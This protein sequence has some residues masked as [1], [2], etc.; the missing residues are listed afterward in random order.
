MENTDTN[1]STQGENQDSVSS[2]QTGKKTPDT[3]SAAKSGEKPRIKNLSF[4]YRKHH[5]NGNARVTVFGDSKLASDEEADAVVSIFGSSTADG[6]VNDAVVSVLGS[7][8]SSGD[9]GDAV[10]SVLGNTRVNGG[11][12]GDAAVAVLGDTYINGHVRDAAVAVLGDI[13]LGPNA[14]VGGDVVSVGGTVK[15]HPNAIVHGNIQNVSIGAHFGGF[16]WFHVWVQ[17]CLL[18]GRPLAFGAQLMWAWWIAISFL[19]L[20]VVL[21]LLFPRGIE[22]CVQTLEHRPGYSLLTALL[23]TLITPL[24]AILLLITIVGL[25]AL[26]VFL[27]V[28]AIFGKAVMLT[29]IG[30]RITPLFGGAAASKPVIAVLVGGVIVLLLYTVP[31]V[32]FI[33]SKLLAW[34]GLGVVVYTIILGTKR[35]PPTTP[36]TPPVAVPLV[37]PESGVAETGPVTAEP[38]AP[39][40]SAT[41]PP[42]PPPVP[43]PLFSAATLVRAGFWIRLAA[44]LLDAVI[45]GLALGFTPHVLRPHFLLLYAGYCV[46]MWALR[47][48]TVGGIVCN[49]KVVRLDD[50]RVDWAT[51]LVRALGG[52]LSFFAAGLGF[53]WV[54]FDDQRQSWHD[55]IAGTTIVIVPKGVSLI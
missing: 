18:F 34:L 1:A 29:W 42:V 49:L 32:G 12:V 2:E 6:S 41:L 22:K 24:A 11:N 3:S 43:A 35:K 51:A 55:K 13:E 17:R 21:A 9:V 54:A 15:R 30:R 5:Q 33:V 27:F 38:S 19:A 16:E 26:I 44:S 37:V 25:P 46:V 14:E 40:T 52:F 48:T 50:R 53:I 28:A 31:F 10:V 23:V 7:S 39:A 45:V 8:T 47:G 20:Y 4:G 36:P